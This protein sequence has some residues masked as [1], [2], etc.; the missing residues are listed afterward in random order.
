MEL[1]PAQGYLCV[2]SQVI[3]LEH[4][5]ECFCYLYSNLFVTEN[6]LKVECNNIIKADP[7]LKFEFAACVLL[8]VTTDQFAY[9]FELKNQQLY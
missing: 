5:A 4:P 7:K 8:R 3:F 6:T 9:M 1:N 2:W